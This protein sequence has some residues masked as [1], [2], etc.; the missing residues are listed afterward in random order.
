MSEDAEVVEV[1]VAAQK[2]FGC[3]LRIFGG[4]T[5]AWENSPWGGE[6]MT[7]ITLRKYNIQYVNMHT[8]YCI[9][10]VYR[11]CVYV[12]IYRQCVYVSIYIWYINMDTYTYMLTLSRVD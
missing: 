7:K 9:H 2:L 1:K 12:S 8:V 11:D 6:G 3:F 10:C 5:G 4:N